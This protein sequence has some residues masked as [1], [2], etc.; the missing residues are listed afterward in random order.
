MATPKH[1]CTPYCEP[2]DGTH[3]LPFMGIP[4]LTL[5]KLLMHY[6]TVVKLQREDDVTPSVVDRVVDAT[7]INRG[8]E[9]TVGYLAWLREKES[10]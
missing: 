7:A 8:P 9:H 2:D 6:P 3:C 4:D 5:D 10:T 1:K